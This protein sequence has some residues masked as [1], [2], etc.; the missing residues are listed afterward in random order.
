MKYEFSEKDH[1]HLLDGKQLTGCST[2]TDVLSKPLNWYASGKACEILGWTNEKIKVNGLYIHVPTEDRLKISNP[3]L[4]DIK[5]MTGLEYLCLLDKAYKA[6]NEFKKKSA[7]KGIDLH[8]ELEQ[9]I[10]DQMSSCARPYDPKIQPF[11]DWSDKNVKTFLW[12]EAHSYDEETFTGGI[13]DA[14]AILNDGS[15]VVFDFKSAKSAYQSHFIQA[16][17]YCL[18]IRKHGIFDKD[19]NYHGEK[20]SPTHIA[21]V[22]FGTEPVIPVIKHCEPYEVAFKCAVELYRLMNLEEK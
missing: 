6:H 15:V 20:P 3:A 1:R 17:G 9:F 14:G 18:Q 22:P 21:I 10:K 7:K 16:G 19:G 8:T 11:I 5:K 2:V 12:A 13:S 4:D